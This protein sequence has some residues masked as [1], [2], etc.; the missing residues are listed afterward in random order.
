MV[1][2]INPTPTDVATMT[3]VP[4]MFAE[5][6]PA[7]VPKNCDAKTVGPTSFP[8]P[9]GRRSCDDTRRVCGRCA[10]LCLLFSGARKKS[11]T[12]H[13]CATTSDPWKM[14]VFVVEHCTI[15]E[16]HELS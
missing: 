9:S 6:C 13:P 16:R 14:P 2:D 10:A 11:A 12:D 8:S 4:A 15:S 5:I 1:E 7:G 3:E